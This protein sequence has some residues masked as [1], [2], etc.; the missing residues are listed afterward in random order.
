[1]PDVLF[2]PDGSLNALRLAIAA[3]SLAISVAYLGPM[4]GEASPLRT[5]VKTAAIAVLALFPLAFLGAQDAPAFALFVLFAA[6]ALSAVGD[7]FLALRDQT[8]FFVPGLLAFLLAHVAYLTAFLPYA[9]APTTAAT[10]AIL[11]AVTAAGVLIVAIT[12]KLGRLRLPVFAYFTVIMAMVAAAFCINAAPW[13]LGAGAAI[14]ALSDSL[15]AVRKFLKPFPG[16]NEAVWI[17]YIAA[18]FMMTAGFLKVILPQ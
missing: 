2:N 9:H 13:Y 3:T 5:A 4:T 18:Q 14:F 6:L 16:I 17:T 10:L 8:R 1:M 12:P 11:A 7:F 15:I